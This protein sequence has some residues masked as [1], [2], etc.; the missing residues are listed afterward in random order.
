MRYSRAQ[1]V[2]H[3]LTVAVLAFMVLSGLA[4]NYDW[5]DTGS[6]RFH[7]LLGQIFIVLLA[8][9][10]ITRLIYPVTPDHADH[11]A[12]EVI[13]AR[14][15]H[16]GL[17]LCMIAYV[18]TGYIAAS[19]LRDPMLLAPVNQAFAR[20]DAGEWLLEAHFTLKW[21][22]LALFTLHFAGALKHLLWQQN[23]PISNMTPTFRKE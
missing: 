21:I 9:R 23:K 3:W 19:G 10:L 15:V 2:Y 4:Y 7:Q 13:A 16:G 6:I 12:F 5:I 18:F 8:A 22:L 17:Y 1:I 20:S 11:T 14:I